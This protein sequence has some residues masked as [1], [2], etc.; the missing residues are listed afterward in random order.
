M[1]KHVDGVITGL[2]VKKGGITKLTIETRELTQEDID[3]IGRSPTAPFVVVGLQ[4]QE[5][6]SDSTAGWDN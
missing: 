5:P 4:V 1:K 2:L 6:E 3:T